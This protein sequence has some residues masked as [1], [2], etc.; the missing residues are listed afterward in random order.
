MYVSCSSTGAKFDMRKDII[1][2]AAQKAES[3]G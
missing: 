1:R 3:E 2:N